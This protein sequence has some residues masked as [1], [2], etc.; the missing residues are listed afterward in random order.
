ML[1]LLTWVLMAKQRSSASD[2]TLDPCRDVS[3]A[4]SLAAANSSRL[5]ADADLQTTHGCGDLVFSSHTIFALTGMMTYNEYG[6]HLAT[7]VALP[8]PIDFPMWHPH[9]GHCQLN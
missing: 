8:W 5:T 6:T 9:F 7:K 1:T 2:A 4:L 3:E